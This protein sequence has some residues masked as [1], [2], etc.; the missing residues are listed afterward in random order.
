MLQYLSHQP[1]PE[2]SKGKGKMIG[3]VKKWRE[4]WELTAFKLI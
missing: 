1:Q 2:S 3:S 4:N